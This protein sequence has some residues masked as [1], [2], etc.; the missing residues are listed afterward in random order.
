M[1]LENGYI[2]SH[3]LQQ[4]G[5]KKSKRRVRGD[6][7]ASL[8]KKVP[9]KK[10]SSDA[11]KGDG[12][13]AVKL[14][15]ALK[16]YSDKSLDQ[17]G[18]GEEEG[19][20]DEYRQAFSVPQRHEGN[21]D[22][23]PTYEL[24]KLPESITHKKQTQGREETEE[25]NDDD[26][27][28]GEGEETL[29]VG[30]M[31]EHEESGTSKEL[32]DVPSLGEGDQVDEFEDMAQQ[33]LSR[34]GS[35]V[36]MNNVHSMLLRQSIYSLSS[37]T[38]SHSSLARKSYSRL[39]R[40]LMDK[41]S[42]LDMYR[43][44]AKK[45]NDERVQLEYAKFLIHTIETLEGEDKSNGS[46]EKT[47]MA[48]DSGIGAVDGFVMGTGSSS[49]SSTPTQSVRSFQIRAADPA[50]DQNKA[51]LISEAIYWIRFLQ[52]KGNPE[53]SY[54]LGCWLEDGKYGVV[55][56]RSKA[57]KCFMFAAKLHH[58]KAACKVAHS[59]EARGLTS[60]AFSYFKLASSL[61]NSSAN[62]RMGIAL[63]R[64]ELGQ[65]KN[66]KQAIIYLRRSAE[67]ADEDCPDG[68][69]VLALIFLGEYPDKALYENVFLDTEEAHKLL[70]TAANLGMPEAQHKLGYLFEFG[71]YGFPANPYGSIMYYRL[72][73]E[74]GYALSQMALSGW[75]LSGAAN[76]LEQSD[77][78]AFDWCS[79]A[80]EQNL[81]RAQFGMGYYYDIGIG[82]ERDLDK[83]IE[84][85][86]LA[87]KNG[88]VE[89]KDRLKKSEAERAAESGGSLRRKVT[90]GRQQSLLSRSKNKKQKDMCSI[91]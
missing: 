86:S 22:S 18:E 40:T 70:E 29:S 47:L 36:D 88:N 89:A 82:V 25:D 69:Y 57:F 5:G 1:E 50:E 37:G 75:Y 83:A 43:E 16:G 66:Y 2:E 56:D 20:E 33:R 80:A 77:A 6:R 85:Y 32:S 81:P 64:G 45:T 7:N 63:L 19:E 60:R 24:P 67:I 78:L 31:Y 38:Q 49:A 52:K 39:S 61:G 79:K 21:E 59:Y 17:E 48:R 30:K 13:E 51:N 91:M 54:T 76:V 28:E 9:L 53:A 41:G 73:A 10:E 26:S 35:A 3:V 12:L 74:K 90:I 44:A 15:Y 71:E 4:E 55:A 8:G 14:E 58:N 62:Y 84:W 68:A 87:A 27:G 72:A 11:L 34:Y 42:A 23:P 65:K 46:S